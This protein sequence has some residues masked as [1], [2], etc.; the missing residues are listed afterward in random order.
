MD[1]IE[2]LQAQLA[3]EEK[4][5][6][7]AVATIMEAGGTVPRTTGKLLLTSDGRVLGTV[8]GG[9]S[10]RR[11]VEEARQ[12]LAEGKN[13]IVTLGHTCGDSLSK[14]H[15]TVFIEVGNTKPRL[16][17][18][19]AGHVGRAIL[20]LGRFAGF[21]TVL[22][23]TR[24]EETIRPAIEAADQF[25]PGTDYYEELE[26]HDFPAD[27]A[28]IITTFSHQTDEQALHSVMKRDFSYVG[29]LGSRAKAEGIRKR[30]TD[31]GCEAEKVR[32]LTSPMGLDLGGETPEEIAVSVIAQ[33][34]QVRNGKCT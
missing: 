29:M 17:V 21:A 2:L 7:Y 24:P 23:D 14:G 16:V 1:N 5:R 9:S 31:A 32:R 4:G 11:A 34:M 25:F 10:E 30:L 20:Q 22:I 6:P 28:Y 26:K 8:G 3:E 27:T 19:G 18:V 13:R 12:A 15:I 33:V